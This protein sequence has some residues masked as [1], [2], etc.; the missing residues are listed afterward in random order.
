MAEASGWVTEDQ[1]V[2]FDDAKSYQDFEAKARAYIGKHHGKTLAARELYFRI[3]KCT[4]VDEGGYQDTHLLTSQDD[5]NKIC[6]ALTGL[7]NKKKRRTPRLEIFQDYFGLQTQV[8]SGEPF[9]N[10][11]RNEIHNLM[12]TKASNNECYI[13]RAELNVITSNLMIRRIVF[14]DAKLNMRRDEK[15]DF[16]QTVQI[17]ARRLLVMC[18]GASL[19]MSCLKELLD[20]GHTDAKLPLGNVQPCHTRCS[21]NFRGLINGQGSFMAAEFL[22]IGQHQKFSRHIV[23]PIHYKEVRTQ[24]SHAAEEKN[25][26]DPN[27]TSSYDD[28]DDGHAKKMACCGRG[29]YSNVY[30]VNIDPDHHRLSKVS[31]F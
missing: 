20:K 3:G 30:R 8:V 11:L 13:P 14:E 25:A 1:T 24:D 23:V 2:P 7:W 4:I 21:A 10:T 31:N 15:N 29:A 12:K 18:V 22:T 16:I 17:S 6:L 26:S 28:N 9:A 27:S 5:W 19:E